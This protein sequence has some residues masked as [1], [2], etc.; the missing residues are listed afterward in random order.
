MSLNQS[1]PIYPVVPQNTPVVSLDPS[2]IYHLVY[3]ASHA[4][5]FEPGQ[6]RDA[7]PRLL[8]DHGLF[9][10]RSGPEL[11]PAGFIDGLASCITGYVL[12]YGELNRSVQGTQVMLQQQLIESQSLQ[13]AL[14]H[15]RN[16][17]IH[18]RDEVIASRN[19]LETE[20]LQ[21]H[22]DHSSLWGCFTDLKEELQ[23]S[24][25]NVG[26]LNAKV[27]LMENEQVRLDMAN[28]HLIEAQD[29]LVGQNNDLF[30]NLLT[31]HESLAHAQSRNDLTD[32]L[33][34]LE[35]VKEELV[36]ACRDLALLQSTAESLRDSNALHLSMLS[37]KDDQICNLNTK[38][39][40]LEQQVSQLQAANA[41]LSQQ[42]TDLVVANNH[43]SSTLDASVAFCRRISSGLLIQR[44]IDLVPFVA[45]IREDLAILIRHC[46]AA[47][48]D[49]TLEISHYITRSLEMIRSLTG[50]AFDSRSRRLEFIDLQ[51]LLHYAEEVNDV[52]HGRPSILFLNLPNNHLN[53]DLP[54]TLRSTPDST[55]A[56][57][58]FQCLCFQSPPY[59]PQSPETIIDNDLGEEFLGDGDLMYPGLDD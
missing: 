55:W 15:E 43:T 41:V 13:A 17:L 31:T 36:H 53:P 9:D 25:N 33:H 5:S 11:I 42:H 39:H 3:L 4:A 2:S 52:S 54:A 18:H 7:V 50:E 28:T 34:E 37:H 26:H 23:E 47:D 48:W 45:A 59:C 38:V 40:S 58:K 32:T 22:E 30:R 44:S 10:F 19:N 51:E 6:F 35:G 57:L 56:T 27:V 24:Q 29:A 16:D 1:S 49:R 21:L 46:D 8:Q 20:L 14:E 12:G